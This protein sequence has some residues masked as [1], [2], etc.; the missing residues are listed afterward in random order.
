MATITLRPTAIEDKYFG[1]TASFL[2]HPIM[3]VMC[4]E[5]TGTTDTFV[6]GSYRT[7]SVVCKVTTAHE[8]ATVS[9]QAQVCPDG[10]WCEIKSFA[11]GTTVTSLFQTVGPFYA[12]KAVIPADVEATI[13]VMALR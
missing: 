9:L 12:L 7:F 1:E 3:A 13:N 11:A 6:V 2:Q 5:A 10:E 8:A 4:T